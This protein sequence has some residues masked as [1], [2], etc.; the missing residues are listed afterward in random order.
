MS[1]QGSSPP[2][3]MR[4]LYAIRVPSGESDGHSTFSCSV[5][6]RAVVDRAANQV[7][8]APGRHRR[9]ERVAVGG[10][11]DAPVVD[12]VGRDHAAAAGGGERLELAGRRAAAEVDQRGLGREAAGVG[13]GVAGDEHRHGAP[14][15]VARHARPARDA[16]DR[17]RRRGRAGRGRRCGR[18]SRPRSRR[19]APRRCR[20]P[21]RS[22]RA[23]SAARRA[24]RRRRPRRRGRCRS[25][26]ASPSRGCG[27]RPPG[28]PRRAPRPARRA[29]RPR[30]SRG[31]RRSRPRRSLRRS[32]T[33]QAS[34]DQHEH[35]DAGHRSSTG[36]RGPDFFS[37]LRRARAARGAAGP[38]RCAPARAGAR[39]R[40]PRR[41]ARRPRC[42]AGRCPAARC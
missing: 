33:R 17:R 41:R 2:P 9:V 29:R 21:R 36:R 42:P 23:R 6:R 4:F 5:R 37:L 39:G 30:S 1:R 22:G 28:D 14:A 3:S 18:G 27:R 35:A 40:R 13:V 16:R 24:G 11:G 7:G 31:R 26:R 15:A 38:R 34:S 10:E 32:P 12:V 25:G 8:L 19:R 20:R